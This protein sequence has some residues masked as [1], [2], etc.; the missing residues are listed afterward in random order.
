MLGLSACDPGLDS[1]QIMARVVSPN[2]KRDA[3]HARDLGGSATVA[4]HDEVFVVDQGASL[5]MS[6]R[7]AT[8]ERVC[9]LDV[10]WLDDDLVEITYFARRA[11]E[12]RRVSRSASVGVR[13]RWLGQDA[14]NG[15]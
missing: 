13:Y 5:R 9:R 6:A 14:A 4:S 2:G 12:D 15:C 11:I 8:L 10:R 1:T 7:V 3:V